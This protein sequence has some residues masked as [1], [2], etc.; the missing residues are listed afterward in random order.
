MTKAIVT[1]KTLSNNIV[2]TKKHSAIIVFL[3]DLMPKHQ[4]IQCLA[5][6]KF[7]FTIKSF[8]LKLEIVC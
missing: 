5:N 8:S 4:K 6:I 3:A 7:P 2:T 1:M